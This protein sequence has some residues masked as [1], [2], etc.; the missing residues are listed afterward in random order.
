MAHNL[1]N[2][3]PESHDNAICILHAL[4]AACSAR[5]K[6]KTDGRNREL[7]TMMAS[8]ATALA[9]VVARRLTSATRRNLSVPA[10]REV[11]KAERAELRAVRR[12]RSAALVQ[13]EGGGGTTASGGG[14]SASGSGGGNTMLGPRVV[15]GVGVGVPT[16]LLFWGIYDED[17][18]PAKLSRA[19]GLTSKITDFTDEFA[20]PAREKLLPDWH[21][22]CKE[23]KAAY[24]YA[25]PPFGCTVP[26]P[27]L[28]RFVSPNSYRI[29]MPNVPH[30]IPVPHTLVLD[31]ENTLVSSTWDRKYGWRHAKRPGVD[32]FLTELA[33]YYEI[34]LYSPSHEGVA[35]PV[36]ASLDK[37]GFIM[38]RLYRDATYYRD[39]VHCKDLESLNRNTNRMIIL[40]DD[41]KA[42]RGR[43]KDNLIL[44]KPYSDPNDRDDRT[45]QRITPLLIEIAKEGYSNIPEILR[46]FRGLD[47]DGIADEYENR[48]AEVR[49]R[50]Q[51]IAHRGLGAFSGGSMRES[52]PAPELTPP[53]EPTTGTPQQ[54]TAKDLVGSAPPPASGGGVIGWFNRRQKDQE[55][56]QMRKMEKWNEVMMKRHK[57]KMERQQQQQ[58][59]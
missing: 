50:R 2:K 59:A 40:D 5:E 39:G 45:L 33:Q 6:Q 3:Y 16:A 7:N 14:A 51:R 32:K 30:D 43:D 38:H 20:K 27:F 17:S 48:T 36:V 55:E 44:V 19:A 1:K 49:A 42:V 13:A 11:S 10:R 41:P 58:A 57:E 26:S 31:L 37:S 9:A 25:M 18:P 22:V 8:S 24:H 28:L 29:Q 46:Q 53:P 15:Y 12:E 54:L 23:D 47:A 52:M 34:V 35:E 56:E 21:Q 4:H